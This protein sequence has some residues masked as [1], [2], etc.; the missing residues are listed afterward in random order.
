MKHQALNFSFET[1]TGHKTGG[2]TL[3]YDLN[4]LPYREGK[5]VVDAGHR[6]RRERFKKPDAQVQVLSDHFENGSVCEF[7]R[8][9]TQG[10]DSFSLRLTGNYDVI[11]T[12]GGGWLLHN[13]DDEKPHLWLPL[14]PTARGYDKLG[15]V[16]S[17]EILP[18]IEIC[19][20]RNDLSV[21]FRILKDDVFIEFVVWT[22][23]SKSCLFEELSSLSAREFQR[24]FLWA[25]HTV[26]SG[27]E[28]L[29][30]NLIHG[31]VY[32][33]G[34]PWSRPPWRRP[35]C[36]V[37][38]HAL[39]VTFHSLWR[40]T[41]KQIYQQMKTQLVFSVI[42][43]QE[44]DGAWR[45]G[46]WTDD[47]EVHY[48]HHC[49]G[50][51]LLTADYEETRDVVVDSSLRRAVDYLRNQCDELSVGRWYLHDSLELSVESM[52]KS[53]ITYQYSRVLGK[54]PSNMLVLNTHLDA[55]VALNRYEKLFG[56]G[57]LEKEISSGV[58]ATVAVL[59]L[60]SAELLYRILF[61]AIELTFMP[62]SA[63]KTMSL[64]VRAL[65]RL[66]REKMIP[67]L[68]RIKRIFPRIVMPNGY[69]D[70]NL[71]LN[72]FWYPYFL[73]N[74]MD[75]LRF[76]K[77]FSVK[78][79]DSIID[80][81]VNFVHRVGLERWLN[82]ESTAYAVCF[83]AEAM[84][85]YCLH[86]PNRSRAVLAEAVIAL[87]DSEQGIPPSLL[88]CNSEYIRLTGQVPC[89][90]TDND[91]LLIINLSLDP[92]HIEFLLINGTDSP[93]DT[94]I[95]RVHDKLVA[96]DQKGGSVSVKQT[97]TVPARGWLRLLSYN[98]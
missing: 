23:P 65:R 50:I 36:E 96:L 94:S 95:P 88:G 25:S 13:R 74:I 76:Q 91:A 81:A 80:N 37:V 29:Y 57:I 19:A 71:T 56:Q 55:L 63:A 35:Y 14:Q 82:N 59:G 83:W 7:T 2:R 85:L 8:L 79:V 3:T 44:E 86:T 87:Y 53:P 39:Y 4:H 26:Y 42:A 11:C 18:I 5:I 16:V 70:R 43:R 92:R 6:F 48:R 31:A 54:S 93:Q 61:Q 77:C 40:A 89:L 30:K 32:K 22:L 72:E 90:W 34:L 66:T 84:Y 9:L 58:D 97:L 68:P 49:S 12:Q 41:R 67:R 73:I 21:L 52:R 47:F 27:P 69:I 60:K 64:P 15:R 38:A 98:G 33:T 20:L 1:A 24:I 51:H 45:H 62:D 46:S 78:M 75:L 28:D 10:N 17:E